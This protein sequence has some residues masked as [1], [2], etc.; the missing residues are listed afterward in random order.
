M[1]AMYERDPQELFERMNAAKDEGTLGC[2]AIYIRNE[3]QE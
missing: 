3:T 2:I 1:S